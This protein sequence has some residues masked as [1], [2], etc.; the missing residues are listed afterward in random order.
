M[1][2]PLVLFLVLVRANG[3]T[4]SRDG[5]CHPRFLEC[6]MFCEYSC[7]HEMDPRRLP[8]LGRKANVLDVLPGSEWTDCSMKDVERRTR[9]P[10]VVAH[11]KILFDQLGLHSAPAESA[12]AHELDSKRFKEYGELAKS[13]P[14]MLTW[15]CSNHCEYECMHRTVQSLS[16]PVK[17]FGKWP[18]RRVLICQEFLSSFYSFVNA[19]PY[20]ILTLNQDFQRYAQGFLKFYAY[21]VLLMWISSGVFHCRDNMFTMHLDYFTAF[22]G[23]VANAWLGLYLVIHEKYKRVLSFG[24]SALWVFHVTYL[25]VFHFDFEWNMILASSLAV[26]ANLSWTRWYLT[27]RLNKAHAWMALVTTWSLV[28]LFLMMEA[29][30]FPPGPLGL[31]DAHS[32]WHLSTIPVS[33]LWCIFFYREAIFLTNSKSKNS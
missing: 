19:L 8:L 32:F 5:K 31:A 6:V 11:L 22:A 29:N 7:V 3:E 33:V 21:L 24:A 25:S 12:D 2:G 4:W 16:E 18:F 30:D 10:A 28:P 9:L 23:V 20:A 27:N 14:E 26:I 15:S 13:N 17:F 1:G